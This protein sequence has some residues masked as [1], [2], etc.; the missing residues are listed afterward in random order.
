M[1]CVQGRTFS[2][3][4]E[5]CQRISTIAHYLKKAIEFKRSVQLGYLHEKLKDAILHPVLTTHSIYKF[6]V[7]PTVLALK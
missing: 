6:E 5:N 2:D 4:C 7:D 3:L 1:R